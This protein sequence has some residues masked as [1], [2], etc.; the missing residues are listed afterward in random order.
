MAQICA[1]S[2]VVMKTA[3]SERER[4]GTEIFPQP[5]AA[6]TQGAL[7]KVSSI[8]MIIIIFFLGLF[9]FCVTLKEIHKNCAAG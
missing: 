3:S 1:D 2:L 4:G 8:I 5:S 9:V 6:D 7:N